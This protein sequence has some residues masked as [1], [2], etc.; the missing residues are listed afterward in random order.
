VRSG[1]HRVSNCLECA[2]KRPEARG[3]EEYPWLR[4]FPATQVASGS[5]RKQGE[6]WN[7]Q[8]LISGSKVRV[9]VRPPY[10]QALS[11]L[12]FCV[13]TKLRQLIS[14]NFRLSFSLQAFSVP[15]RVAGALCA[16]CTTPSCL[17]SCDRSMRGFEHLSGRHHR[18]PCFL[19]VAVP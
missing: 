14:T 7:T 17:W 18:S 15:R 12:P 19:R 3:S 4:R 10:N 6:P 8:L 5:K 11:W 2:R 13:S 1:Q 16:L 9:L